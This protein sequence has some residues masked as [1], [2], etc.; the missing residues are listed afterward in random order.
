MR[1][2]YGI[3]C[4]FGQN[5]CEQLARRLDEHLIERY[6]QIFPMFNPT[7]WLA[8]SRQR[9]LCLRVLELIPCPCNCTPGDLKNLRL[10]I[11]R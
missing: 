10:F 2:R 3:P 8:S 1:V 5:F 4:L 6:W 7:N 11:V 9:F